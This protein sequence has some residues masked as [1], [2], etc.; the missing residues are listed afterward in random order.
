MS[1]LGYRSVLGNSQ[2]VTR[3]SIWFAH[4]KWIVLIL[5]ENQAENWFWGSHP[6]ENQNRFLFLFFKKA[7]WIFTWQPDSGSQGPKQIWFIGSSCSFFSLGVA[8][9]LLLLLIFFSSIA[10]LSLLFF[11]LYYYHSSHMVLFFSLDEVIKL[12]I[13]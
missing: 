7:G 4:W 8:T 2:W 11:S 10:L 13:I 6:C 12:L 5:S 3:F 1:I 9:L